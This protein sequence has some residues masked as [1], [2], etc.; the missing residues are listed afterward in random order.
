MREAGFSYEAHKKSYY[1]DRHEDDDVVGD[2][3]EYIDEDL[4]EEI[5]EHCWIQ[6]PKRQYLKLKF[7]G[8]L[9]SIRVKQ[10]EKESDVEKQIKDF[11]D[12]KLTYF[13]TDTDGNEFAEVHTDVLYSYSDDDKTLPPLG[14]FG[15]NKSVRLKEGV[16]PR[17]VFG[18]DEA[19]F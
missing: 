2:R 3:H 9:Q 19:I 4:E 17:L 5:Y 12:K 15:G 7:K 8:K 13:Y 16:K 14:E 10:E 18:Q 1:V 6:L 11:L